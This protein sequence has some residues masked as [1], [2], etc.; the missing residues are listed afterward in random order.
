MPY[1]FTAVPADGWEFDHYETHVEQQWSSGSIYVENR[2]NLT[3]NPFALYDHKGD[4]PNE[5]YTWPASRW[6]GEWTN[7]NTSSHTTN[8][9]YYLKYEITAVFRRV[10]TNLLVNSSTVESPAKLVYDPTTNKL[11]ADY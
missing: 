8:H 1:V 4:L 3:I 11:V 6:L 9:S 2:L 10:P 7:V 5:P